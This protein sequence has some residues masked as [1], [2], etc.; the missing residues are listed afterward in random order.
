MFI[1]ADPPSLFLLLLIDFSNPQLK[2]FQ[3]IFKSCA[4][5][6]KGIFFLLTAQ[7]RKKGA[8]AD[9]EPWP[10]PVWSAAAPR[11]NGR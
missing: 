2:F 5:L 1:V 4:L 10:A 8:I 9:P 3:C 7:S 11:P 6:L